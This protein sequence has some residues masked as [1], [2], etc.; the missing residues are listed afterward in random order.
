MTLTPQQER[1][2]LE[3]VSSEIAS[4]IKPQLDE[5]R[6]ITIPQAAEILQCGQIKARKLLGSYV[7]LGERI[8]RVPLS[9]VKK[10]IQD[11]T[12]KA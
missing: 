8:S 6:L 11:R 5:V 2:V 9:A 12:V 4:A 7:D 10:L 3:M 1:Q